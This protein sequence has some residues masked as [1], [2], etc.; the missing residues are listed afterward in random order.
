MQW[1][2]EQALNIS[3]NDI[4]IFGYYMA[5]GFTRSDKIRKSILGKQ[6]IYLANVIKQISVKA[7]FSG[8]SS[9]RN[10]Y[11]Y[12]S[13]LYPT[14]VCEFPANECVGFQPV[15]EKLVIRFS[16]RWY[17][18]ASSALFKEWVYH[19]SFHKVILAAN[20]PFDMFHI[21]MYL[22]MDAICIPSLYGNMMAFT[23]NPTRK[24]SDWLLLPRHSG[25]RK[26]SF[27]NHILS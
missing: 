20:N 11:T 4:D 24:N 15:A 7:W 10:N 25:D 12:V 23:Y 26:N 13:K 6:R 18:H 17:H 27:K 16:H 19:D 1:L 3:K 21:K 5:G 2:L 22:G 8:K 14:I 9:E